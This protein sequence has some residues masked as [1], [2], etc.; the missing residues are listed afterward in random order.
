M[1]EIGFKIVV[2]NRK[3]IS[4]LYGH[5]FKSF[6]VSKIVFMLK[7]KLFIAFFLMQSSIFAWAQQTSQA[8]PGLTPLP[9]DSAQP[10]IMSQSQATRSKLNPS[11]R[12]EM[13]GAAAS[14]AKGL[15]CSVFI[16][17][18]DWLSI[19]FV[20]TAYSTYKVEES[21][22]EDYY[23]GLTMASITAQSRIVSGSTKTFRGGAHAYTMDVNL[24]PVS[25]PFYYIG[26]LRFSNVGQ[27]KISLLSALQKKTWDIANVV[28]VTYSPFVLQSK[29]HY[30]W[31]IGTLIHR[32]VAPN[33]DTYIMYAFTNEV[34]TELKRETLIDLSGQL[35][36]PDGWRYENVLLNKT[37][38][39]RP[40]PFNDFGSDVLFDELNNFYVKYQK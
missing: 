29:I 36:L 28:N 6:S 15:V 38:T 12:V 27:V 34:A 3:D 7:L 20:L 26:N 21:C 23:Y 10:G 31:N 11:P 16:S 5:S 18:F 25:N 1:F 9:V 8:S 13:D 37:I 33:G 14:N 22:N 2:S 32:L 19:S 35:R 4:S 24:S 17:H 39:V 40:T 30:I